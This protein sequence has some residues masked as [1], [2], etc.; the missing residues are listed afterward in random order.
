M[1]S[2]SKVRCLKLC[3]QLVFQF[4]NKWQIWSNNVKV[5]DIDC[6]VH[7][8][9]NRARCHR[10]IGQTPAFSSLLWRYQTRDK[11]LVLDRTIPEEEVEP[12]SCSHCGSVPAAQYKRA[13]SNG[14]WGMQLSYR[15]GA[16]VASFWQKWRVKLC[17]CWSWLRLQKSQSSQ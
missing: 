4:D 2:W 8:Y 15:P 11:L 6:N 1:R 14:S 9:S 7:R 3:C 10:R 5:I 12:G 17:W 13:R 16:S